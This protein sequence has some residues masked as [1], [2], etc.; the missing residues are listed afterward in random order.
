M[1]NLIKR[2]ALT[3]LGLLALGG[4]VKAQDS[5]KTP[6]NI[7]FNNNLSSTYFLWGTPFSEEPV[8]QKF[9]NVNKGPFNLGI[10]A[11]YD[12]EMGQ[13]NER[14]L[15]TDYTKSFGKLNLTGG[16]GR[17]HA[18][19]DGVWEKM[20]HWSGTVSAKVPFNPSI[21]YHKM[22]GIMAGEYAQGNLSLELPVNNDLSVSTS[23]K[24]GYNKNFLR[25][26]KGLSHVEAGV[27]LPWKATDNIT[28]TPYFNYSYPL[29]E[30][31]SNTSYNGVNVSLGGK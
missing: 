26:G 11:N 25:E 17:A 22:D 28:V 19:V 4:N 18:K 15:L 20:N 30:D 5:T 3:G 6:L 1:A 23:A 24:V 12:F 31:F 27:S 21:E 13:I 9:L 29:S 8:N 10:F 14:V 16:Y 2:I 7:N